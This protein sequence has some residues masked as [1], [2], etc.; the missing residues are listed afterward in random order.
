MKRKLIVKQR[1]QQT[2]EDIVLAESFI[3][4]EEFEK[5]IR[6]DYHENDVNSTKVHIEA[7]TQ[8]LHVHRFGEAISRLVFIEGQITSGLIESE[9]GSF[10][11][12]LYTHR[13][14]SNQENIVVEY[15]VMNGEEVTDTY[16][17]YWKIRRMTHE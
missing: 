10:D 12:E 3:D 17:I 4:I 13:Y 5:T 11:V 2:Q 6:F 15:D 8:E 9:F 7:T 16:R 14:I 1:N